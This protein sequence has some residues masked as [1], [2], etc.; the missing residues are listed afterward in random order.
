MSY[1]CGVSNCGGGSCVHELLDA[2]CP[3][4]GSRMVLVKSNGHKFCSND[5]LACD[6]EEDF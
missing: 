3:Y 6:Y 5:D 4:C 2:T 1:S